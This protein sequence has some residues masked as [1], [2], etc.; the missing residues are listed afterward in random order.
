MEHGRLLDL[1][2]ASFVKKVEKIILLKKP[3]SHEE[4]LNAIKEHAKYGGVKFTKL[5]SVLKELLIEDITEKVAWNRK[6]N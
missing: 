6:C 5:W 1:T 2:L 4:L 3:T